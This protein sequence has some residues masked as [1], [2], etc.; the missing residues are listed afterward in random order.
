MEAIDGEQ[1]LTMENR[2]LKAMLISLGGTAAPVI[3]SLNRQKPEYICFFVSEETRESVDKDILPKL[4]FKCLHH[5][6]I[7]TSNAERL[8]ECYRALSMELPDILKKWKVEPKDLLVDY[9]GGT[10]TMSVALAL[11][12]I[13]GSSRYSY[14]GGDECSRGGTGVVVNGKERMWF[15]DNPW[16]EIALGERKGGCYFL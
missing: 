5:Q 13:D 6:W 14:V 12:A 11:A 15:L 10:E 7:V 3:F 9:T 1:A 8:S 4:A 2:R 16:D